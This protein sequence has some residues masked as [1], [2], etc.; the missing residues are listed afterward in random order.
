MIYTTL[1]K[2]DK[3]ANALGQEHV[4]VMADLAIYS[5]A[6]QI[7]W[8]EPD[9]LAGRVMMNALYRLGK[10]TTYSALTKNAD[11]LQGLEAFQ[12]V[13]TFLDTARRFVLLMHIVK[14]LKI[15]VH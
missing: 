5:K 6:E 1:L 14:I 9:P 15:S 4:L 3:I 8:T 12:D 7:L 2:L 10:R 11:A 13:H